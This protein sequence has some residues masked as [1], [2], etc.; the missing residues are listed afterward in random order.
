MNSL[1]NSYFKC[2]I[3]IGILFR[4]RLAIFHKYL[5]NSLVSNILIKDIDKRDKILLIFMYIHLILKFKEIHC[6]ELLIL[7]WLINKQKSFFSSYYK[8]FTMQKLYC[9]ISLIVV[10]SSLEQRFKT[11]NK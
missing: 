8:R 2:I 1:M 9:M 5:E 11:N 10:K 7:S 4:Q 6:C 3:S